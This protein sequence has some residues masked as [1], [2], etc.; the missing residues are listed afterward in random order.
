MFK[1]NKEITFEENTSHGELL[2]LISRGERVLEF[3][4]AKGE[5]AGCIKES[6]DCKVWG[7]E[8]DAGAFEIARASLEG[9]VACDIENY[10][11]EKEFEGILFDTLLFADVLEHLRDPAKAIRRALPLLKDDGKILFSVP[12][13]AHADIILKLL[14]N[15]FDYT[16]IGLLD[17]TH[18][19]FFAKENLVP[20]CEEAGIFPTLITSL[21]ASEDAEEYKL[22]CV[23]HKLE[24]ARDNSLETVWEAR[25]SALIGASYTDLVYSLANENNALNKKIEFLCDEIT[26]LEELSKKRKKD[27]INSVLVCNDLRGKLEYEQLKYKTISGSFFWKIT[28]PLRLLVDLLKWPFR[29]ITPLVL[30]KK[31][32][33]TWKNQGFKTAMRKVSQRKRSR[34]A[35]AYIEGLNPS[36]MELEAQ[37]STVF[38][39][40]IKFSILVPLYNTPETFLCEMIDSVIAQTY[41]NWE[42]CLADGSDDKHASVADV[43]SKYTSKDSRI[44]YKK[45]EKNLGISENTNACIDMSTGNFIALFDHDDVLHPSALYYMMKAICEQN[46]DYVYTDELTFES[47][48]I[49]KILTVHC[50]PDFAIDNLRA[51]NYICHFSAFSRELLD[52]A[53]RFRSEFDGSQD[54]DLILRLTEQARN[55]VHI[56]RVLYFWRSHPAS[57]A[58]D[59]NSKTYAFEAGRKAVFESVQRAGYDAI[60][61]SSKVF[62]TIYRI[63]YALKASPKV[64][65]IIENK[66]SFKSISSCV[67]SILS[68]TSY[69]NYEIIIADSSSTD[70]EVL[71]YYKYLKDSGKAQICSLVGPRSICSAINNAV[72]HASGDF[73]VFLHND[74]RIIT[75]NWI[76]EMLMYGQRDDVGIVGAM[77]YYPDDTIQH[78][79]LIL[80]MGDSNGIAGVPFRECNRGEVGY[81]GRLWYSQNMSA[82]SSACMMIKASLFKK[83]GGFDETLSNVYADVDLCLRARGEG[84]L[85]VWTPYAEAYHNHDEDLDDLSRKNEMDLFTKKWPSL[86]ESNDPYFNPNL[87]PKSIYFDLNFS[88]GESDD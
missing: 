75:P 34:N 29:H 61:E 85:I 3:G 72:G 14:N 2:R 17:N 64:S 52:K 39:K 5:L 47:P 26:R 84:S 54:H 63:S 74:I 83:L 53:G 50:K 67:D 37:R 60:V 41:S 66:N 4:C 78:A 22:L 16:D 38:D 87:D 27:H 65:I 9:G 20:F 56:P 55:V 69:E 59:I 31:F 13:I 11:W 80:H 73:L 46:A 6:L 35:S 32:L 71:S 30:L 12:N 76:E 23:A 77:L 21:D 43:V 45:L 51:N 25:A 49:N 44:V 68:M 28:K 88:K 62:P 79:G 18:I 57:V 15:R 24:F 81:M 36:P 7:I 33:K 10:E 82:V 58:G 48:N 1:Y 86:L 40:D 8:L 70:R 42:L 19:H